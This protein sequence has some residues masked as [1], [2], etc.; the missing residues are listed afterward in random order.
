MKEFTTHLLGVLERL[1]DRL[2]IGEGDLK[3]IVFWP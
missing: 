1:D 2:A 3:S